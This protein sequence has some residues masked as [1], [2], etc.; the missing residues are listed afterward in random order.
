MEKENAGEIS[1]QNT[2]ND[3]IASKPELKA[4]A[5]KYTGEG[6]GNPPEKV[7]EILRDQNK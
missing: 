2:I 7:L 5:D 1:P 6:Y 4:V 3:L